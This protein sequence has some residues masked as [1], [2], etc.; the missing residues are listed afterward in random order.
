M[1]V[2]WGGAGGDNSSDQ[3]GYPGGPALTARFALAVTNSQVLAG[4]GGGGA[5]GGGGGRTGR[6]N[7]AGG[8]YG[9]PGTFD[10]GGK[11]GDSNL[12]GTTGPADHGGYYAA[13]GGGWGAAG[14]ASL[15]AREGQSV[16]LTAP[17]G[18]GGPAVTGNSYITWLATGTR[19]GSIT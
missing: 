15:W 5:L 2:G 6:V 7:S 16:T 19:Y 8:P 9:S 1:Y 4:G 13:G 10:S 12:G 17:G 18:A 3:A 14:G 11:G